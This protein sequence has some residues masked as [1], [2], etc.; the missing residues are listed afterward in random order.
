MSLNNFDAIVYINLKHRK[1]RNTH[2]LKELTR[3]NVDKDK[4]V[5]IEGNFI[6]FNGHLGCVMSHINA[7]DYAINNNLNNI[8]ILEDDCYFIDNVNFLNSTIEYFLKIVNPWNVFLL[9]GYFEKTQKTNYSYINRVIKGWRSHS[10]AL[11]KSYFKILKE[12]F[13]YS[14]EML[15]KHNTHF[16]GEKYVLDHNWWSLQKKDLWYASN[17]LLTAQIDG[18]SDIMWKERE[19]R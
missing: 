12:N 4:I 3:L 2:I 19:I 10:Y 16:D 18:Y 7:I 11:H 8:L 13:L 5:R 6:P 14:C 9:G 15:H 1:D 17:I